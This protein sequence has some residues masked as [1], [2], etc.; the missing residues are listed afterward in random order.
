MT[1]VP[2]PESDSRKP[3][4]VEPW[5]YVC[6]DCGGQVNRDDMHRQYRCG[7]CDGYYT[8]DQLVD[9]ASDDDRPQYNDTGGAVPQGSL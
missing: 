7:S 9:K 6:P 4:P 8:R 1:S 3:D 2:I 5:R